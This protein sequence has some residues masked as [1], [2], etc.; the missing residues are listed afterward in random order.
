MLI[1][2]I[3]SCPQLCCADFPQWTHSLFPSQTSKGKILGNF[4]LWYFSDGASNIPA[5]LMLLLILATNFDSQQ[6]E[7]WEKNGAICVQ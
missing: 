5:F 3:L 4:T 6:L 1:N 7:K 2:F